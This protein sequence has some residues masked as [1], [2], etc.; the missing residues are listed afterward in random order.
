MWED[1]RNCRRSGARR[2]DKRWELILPRHMTNRPWLGAEIEDDAKRTG[3][4]DGKLEGLEELEGRW[5]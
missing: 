2:G 4:A 5:L 3:L 1:V